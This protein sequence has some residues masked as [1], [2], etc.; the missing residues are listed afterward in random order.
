MV[1][2][3]SITEDFENAQNGGFID[4]ASMRGTDLASKRGTELGSVRGGTEL[5]SDRGSTLGSEAISLL[6]QCRV[7]D[8]NNKK[9]TRAKFEGEACC[10]M[11]CRT[12][13]MRHD[14]ECEARE[15]EKKLKI[16]QLIQHKHTASHIHEAEMLLTAAQS[17]IE[18]RDNLEKAWATL[19]RAM[20]I[21]SDSMKIYNHQSFLMGFVKLGF[22]A[23][24]VGCEMDLYSF[25]MSFPHYWTMNKQHQIE[26]I[27]LNIVGYKVNLTVI[28]LLLMILPLGFF[29]AVFM[30]M[31]SS[32]EEA[33]NGSEYH[34]IQ[35]D[36]EIGGNPQ[37][38][39]ERGAAMDR[40]DRSEGQTR[41]LK[42]YATK[43]GEKTKL[44]YY[45][46]MP[47]LRYYLLIKDPV[48]DDIEGLFRVNA[49]STFT[50]GVAQGIC[51]LFHIWVLGGKITILIR[52]GMFTQGWNLMVT[53]LYFLSPISNKMKRAIQVDTL[54]HNVEEDMMKLYQ[55]YLDAVAQFAEDSARNSRHKE[56]QLNDHTNRIQR[57][58]INLGGLVAQE[59]HKLN[60]LLKFGMEYKLEALGALRRIQY[61]KLAQI[62]Q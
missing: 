10:Q 62:A 57:E 60:E 26:S 44:E 16:Q 6:L 46:F 37:V 52:V 13:G 1:H 27:P 45:H 61:L 30:L 24:I 15:A 12:D 59:E 40:N 42:G 2:Q 3:E 56:T 34:P 33:V 53:L 55:K 19:Q 41:T 23:V 58:I 29:V 14:D 25:I 9:C 49:L 43:E 50:L 39:R 11:C 38:H 4:L 32:K 48:P 18:A 21:D 20:K 22:L 47:I 35:E 5:G 17:D 8:A 36:P 54:K 51:M 28:K 31:S 7:V